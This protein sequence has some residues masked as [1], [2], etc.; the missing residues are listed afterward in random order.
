MKAVVTQEGRF[1]VARLA[2]GTDVSNQI[3]RDIRRRAVEL[4]IECIYTDGEWSV[5]GYSKTAGSF[6]FARATMPE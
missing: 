1:L 4:G 6:S 3:D 5:P 2:D